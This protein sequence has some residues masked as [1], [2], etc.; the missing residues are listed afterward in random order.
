[1]TVHFS[2]GKLKLLSSAS[3]LPV[4]RVDNNQLFN[5]LKSQCT[6]SIARKARLISKRLGIQSRHFCR[7]FNQPGFYA[8]ESNVDLCIRALKTALSD[9][10]LSINSIGYLI[11]HTTT[12]ATQLPP[13]IAWVA[14]ELSLQQ[15]YLEL[16]QACTG[17]ANALQVSA[18]MLTSQSFENIAIVGSE[19]GSMFCHSNNDFMDQTQL[20][21]FV[22]MG[23]GAGAVILA[24]DDQSGRQMI[25]DIYFGHI[26]LDKK[27]AF[28]IRGG[29]SLNPECSSGIPQF[30]HDVIEVKKNGEAL[31]KQG[32]KC[33]LERGYQID[34]FDYILPHQV[35]GHLANLITKKLGI[36]TSKVVLD[37]DTLGNLGSAAIWVSF[38]RLLK[39]GKLKTG[40]RV[41]VL[42]AEATKYMYGGFVYTH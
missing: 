5:L 40:D 26:G 15:P 35:N 25:S 24:N 13:N 7:D 16:R 4:N 6:P 1:M 33:V 30:E 12:P 36:P 10:N 8:N 29:G 34:D 21:N 28:Q 42:G 2:T 17:F 27:P 14:D 3:V 41:L 9:S 32:L 37:A 31:F 19:T 20:I 23:D 18:A 39:S 38:D 11:G 22:Q